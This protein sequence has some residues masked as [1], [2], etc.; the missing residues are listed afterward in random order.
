MMQRRCLS[1]VMMLVSFCCYTSASANTTKL[2]NLA[3]CAG[4]VIG[5]G[6]IDFFM[7]DEAS[8]D[9][10]AH[11]A[12]T[13]Y[14]SEVFSGQYAQ[15]DLQIA[16]Q[17]LGGNVDKVISAYNSETFDSALYE[18]IV[19][20]YRMLSEQL[21]NGAETIITNQAQWD[22]IKN[23]SIETIKRFLRAG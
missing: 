15:S 19:G 9:S 4:V 21:L 14:L 6:A 11:I 20:C 1:L 7:G 3:A 22:E 16:D 8:F 2:D 17:I 10:A 5:N 13:A 12:Y 23:T 18:E